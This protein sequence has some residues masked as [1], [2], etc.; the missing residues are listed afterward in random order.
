M[1]VRD[2]TEVSRLMTGPLAAE[3]LGVDEANP[4]VVDLRDADGA[5]DLRPLTGLIGVVVGVGPA[6][7]AH[8][9]S[10]D[11]L[12]ERPEDVDEVVGAVQAN[13]VAATSLVLH[14]R[15]SEA[16]PIPLAL[17]AESATY[18]ALQAGHEHR[19]W[20]ATRHP[21][22]RRDE[23]DERVRVDRD[24]D[25]MT[26]TLARPATRNAV[27]AAMQAALVDALA[28]AADP[29]VRSVVLRGE[30]S[31]FSSGGDLAEFGSVADPAT[32]HLLRLARSPGAELARI[33]DKTT[34]VVRGACYG[35]G[36]ELPAFA[37]TVIARS[38]TSLTLPE[39][40]MGLIPGAGGTVSLPRRI[41]RQRTAWLAITGRTIDVDTALA[42]RLV[43]RVQYS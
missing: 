12:V 21:R 29:E 36:V 16:L 14:L 11:V 30:G 4:L 31:V 10:V 26:V 5:V 1:E 9:A 39:V 8:A 33:A 23:S 25:E 17:V 38:D 7:S 35:A 20:L 3:V 2:P 42:W 13:P 40:G 43:D 19:R 24:G 15:A 34:V 6:A 37:R 41:G 22:K 18:S 27:D 32:G 28:L